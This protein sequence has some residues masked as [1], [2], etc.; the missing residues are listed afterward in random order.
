[1]RDHKRPVQ[2]MVLKS[3]RIKIIRK[4]PLPKP[5]GRICGASGLRDR[6]VFTERHRF[7]GTQSRELGSAASCG[8]TPQ[9]TSNV[10]HGNGFREPLRFWLPKSDP[11][12]SNLR[13][14]CDGGLVGKI[15]QPTRAM[16]SQWAGWYPQLRCKW[17]AHK[18]QNHYNTA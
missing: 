14:E 5:S 1:M 3:Q 2:L 7:H 16:R 12:R 9:G 10:P 11:P 4:P 17:S 13:K 6:L 18:G 15:T 8:G